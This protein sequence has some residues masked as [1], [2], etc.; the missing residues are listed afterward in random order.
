MIF[1]FFIFI[2]HFGKGGQRRDPQGH[3]LS[4]VL[5]AGAEQTHHPGFL[6]Q[7]VQRLQPRQLPQTAGAAHETALEYVTFKSHLGISLVG[8][9]KCLNRVLGPE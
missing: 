8:A 6:E 9:S 7:L 3:V 2:G 1:Y 4:P 5:A